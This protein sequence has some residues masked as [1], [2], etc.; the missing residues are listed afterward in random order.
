MLD[1]LGMPAG[2]QILEA[3][4]R[5]AASVQSSLPLTRHVIERLLIPLQKPEQRCGA[6]HEVR[7]ESGCLARLSASVRDASK[8]EL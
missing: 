3:L 5:R 4:A 1:S 8:I 2:F 6:G 7:P